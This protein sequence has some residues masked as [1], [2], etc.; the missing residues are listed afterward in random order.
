MGDGKWK[1]GIYSQS[2]LYLLFLYKKIY[3]PFLFGGGDD[4]R[5]IWGTK[6][7]AKGF[8]TK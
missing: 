6:F 3:I 4:G 7:V 8:N 5:G 1:L 2:P